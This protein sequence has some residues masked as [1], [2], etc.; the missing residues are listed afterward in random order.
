MMWYVI[1]H[2][3]PRQERDFLSGRGG[4]WRLVEADAGYVG[5]FDGVGE[6]VG[7]L[8]E[9]DGE[10]LDLVRSAE[11]HQEFD[12]VAEVFDEKVIAFVGGDVA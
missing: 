9:G 11:F 1:E 6:I 3:S 10:V 4:E 12:E 8:G 2:I 5:G 7:V